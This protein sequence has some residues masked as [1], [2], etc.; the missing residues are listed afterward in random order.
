M[1]PRVKRSRL[2]L[3]SIMVF[4]ALFIAVPAHAQTTTL[5]T[6]TTD[7]SGC[8]TTVVAISEGTAPGF[9]DLTA[10]GLGLVSGPYPPSGTGSSTGS[11]SVS[12]TVVV[13]GSSLTA[14]GCGFA[15][16]TPVTLR[17]AFVASASAEFNI[18]QTTTTRTLTA[19]IRVVAPE[20]QG[21]PAGNITI[22]N[23]VSCVSDAKATAS[24]GEFKIAQAGTT[25]TN[26]NSAEC[27]SEAVVNKIVQAP[28]TA[29]VAAKVL[30]RTGVDALPLLAAG[31]ATILLGSVLLSAGRRRGRYGSIV[32]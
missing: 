17:I 2:V 8:F 9:Y 26:N 13:A 15:A 25:I 32:A 10:T 16:N 23:N 7:S 1:Q 3:M 6:V 19:R 24:S 28:A 11:L 30:S 22:N 12:S 31:L 4:G 21:A 18:A 20:A 29:P 5:G 14:S 27:R